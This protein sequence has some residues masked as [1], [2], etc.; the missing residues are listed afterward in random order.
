MSMRIGW[1]GV[2]G[3]VDTRLVWKSRHEFKTVT[4]SNSSLTIAGL[5][6]YGDWRHVATGCTV[7]VLIISA[8]IIVTLALARKMMIGGLYI[9]AS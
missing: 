1:L 9:S 8:R 6:T 4:I 7:L 5:W 2:V 3:V